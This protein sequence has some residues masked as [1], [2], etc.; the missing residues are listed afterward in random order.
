MVRRSIRSRKRG[1]SL[2]EILLAILLLGTGLAVLLQ[3]LSTGLA[4]GGVNEDEI[5]AANLIQ[6]KVEEDRN[7]N[8]SSVVTEA[9]AVVSGFSA[10]SRQVDMTTPQTNLKQIIVT[11]Y[12]IVGSS[13][14][15]TS[16]TT[17]ISNA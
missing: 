8:F 9:K 1:F 11:V 13:E 12:Y 2:L 6:E 14:I 15:S 7:A 16:V 4:A 10:F 5:V 3:V 17:Y